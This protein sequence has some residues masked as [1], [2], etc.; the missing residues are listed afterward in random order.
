MNLRERFMRNRLL[1]TA[2]MLVF[3]LAGLTVDPAVATAQEGHEE[4][5]APAIH[6]AE[7]E[8]QEHAEHSADKKNEI[9]AFIG[10][11]RRLK[12]E[13]DE[14]GLTF[15]LEYVREILPRTAVSLGVEWAGGEI[16]RD[17]VA[18]L[19]LGV[20]PFENWAHPFYLY[21]GTGIEVASIDEVL[22]EDDEHS[23]AAP[24]EPTDEHGDENAAEG[25][26]VETEVDALMRLGIGWAFHVGSFSIIPNLNT[27]IVGEDWALVGGVTLGYRF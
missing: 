26:H 14:T 12:F 10:G 23:E 9:A 16:E 13:E 22:L 24:L 7:G 4:E 27:D 8:H 17:W 19:K 18:M 15:G 20:K 1:R 2:P 11:T 6:Q 21:I 25:E 3:T 5:G